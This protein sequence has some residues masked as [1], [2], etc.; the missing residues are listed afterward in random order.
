MACSK[1][2]F[3][4]FAAVDKLVS[5]PVLGSDG[6][7]SWQEFRKET[8]ELQRESVAPAL[9][10]KRSDRLG[11]GLTSLSEERANE[12][13]VRSEAGDAALGSGY[14]SFKKKNNAEEASERKRRKLIGKR[15]RSDK[16]QY[17]I[18]AETFKGWKFD[19]IFTTRDKRTGYYWDGTDSIK[20][21]NGVDLPTSNKT[22]AS[23]ADPTSDSGKKKKKGNSE[24][25]KSD[26][27]ALMV[28]NDPNNP[29]E[30][31]ASAIRRRNEALKAPPIPAAPMCAGWDSAIDKATGKVY[32][33][34]LMTDQRSWHPPAAEAL[35]EGWKAA[36]DASGKTYYYHSSGTTRW[37]KPR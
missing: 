4:A 23:V 37:Q 27:G 31:V 14:T 18:A 15:V 33:F 21:L 17:Y 11:T 25:E 8:K 12:D 32:Y 3:D 36:D 9:Q 10:V 28:V 35:P 20:K 30:Q 5:K 13:K 2:S 26:G 19:Y 34:N 7:A 24:G 6:A 22:E 29:L 16:N 1:N